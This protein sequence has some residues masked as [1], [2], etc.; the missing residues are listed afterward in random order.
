MLPNARNTGK[1]RCERG[2]QSYSQKSQITQLLGT[3]Q[4]K[5]LPK[6][7]TERLKL[8]AAAV[9]AISA[10]PPGRTHTGTTK[11]GASSSGS[12]K[13]RI[14]DPRLAFESPPMR[15]AISMMAFSLGAGGGSSSALPHGPGVGQAD[16]PMAD[17][18][19]AP[20]AAA[21]QSAHALADLSEALPEDGPGPEV[22]S[23]TRTQAPRLAC[24]AAS[25]RSPP[26]S[27]TGRP[28]GCGRRWAQ[29]GCCPS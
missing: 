13:D 23:G 20:V 25:H 16:V 18:S 6:E 11:G 9:A 17:A 8:V 2:M 29:S 15:G 10:P 27:G 28:G 19:P 21:Q 12:R 14:P 5:V 26:F 3:G 22:R 1:T 4:P 7:Q 24:T